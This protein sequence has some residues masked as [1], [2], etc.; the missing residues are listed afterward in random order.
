MNKFKDTKY[1]RIRL[2]C[3]C[4]HAKDDFCDWIWTHL[5]TCEN[6]MYEFYYGKELVCKV[7][8]CVNG[9]VIYTGY[10][11]C[12]VYPFSFGAEY[13]E[14]LMQEQTDT[15]LEDLVEIIVEKVDKDGKGN[16]IDYYELIH[17]E[18]FLPSQKWRKVEREREEKKRAKKSGMHELRSS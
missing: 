3:L 10:G 15:F 7:Q 1:K 17:S 11:E 14:K 18:E 5:S 16:D 2:Q 12:V 8:C 6:L 9:Y 4:K 13:K